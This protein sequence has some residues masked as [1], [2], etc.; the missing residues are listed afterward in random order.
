MWQ[1][2]KGGVD[3]QHDHDSNK[4][5]LLKIRKQVV[6]SPARVPKFF[7]VIIVVGGTTIKQ[8]PIHSRA[9][10]HD[11]SSVYRAC[12]SPNSRL[13]HSSD[14]EKVSLRIIAEGATRGIKLRRDYRRNIHIR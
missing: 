9:P 14:I 2:N 4:I 8:H 1:S 10:T 13:G 6:E 11:C 3:T 12:N 5:Y 7:P